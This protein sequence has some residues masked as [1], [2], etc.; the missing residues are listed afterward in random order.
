MEIDSKRDI[1]RKYQVHSKI[2]SENLERRHLFAGVGLRTDNI[3]VDLQI[4]GV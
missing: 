2:N 3:K 1:E 4:N